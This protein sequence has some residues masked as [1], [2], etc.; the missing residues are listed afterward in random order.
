MPARVIENE[1]MPAPLGPY[2]HAVAASGELVFISG[3][4]G[5]DTQTGEVPAQFEQQAR[6][7]FENLSRVVAAA[8]LQMADVVKTTVYLADA[9]QFGVLNSLFGQYF[10]I[11]P[12]TRATPIVQLPKG[13]LISIEAV[14]SGADPAPCVADESRHSRPFA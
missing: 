3:Q 13:L 1:N 4:A 9:S 12:P 2:S 10:P 11:S 5:M 8:G 7:A 6:N 14:A